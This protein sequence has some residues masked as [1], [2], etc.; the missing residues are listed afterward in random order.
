MTANRVGASEKTPFLSQT[1]LVLSNVCAGNA[2]AQ[3][4]RAFHFAE[5]WAISHTCCHEQA[6]PDSASG[7]VLSNRTLQRFFLWRR[8]LLHRLE[9]SVSKIFISAARI[10][11]DDLHFVS[12]PEILAVEVASLKGQT[13]RSNR[14]A[15]VFSSFS[16]HQFGFDRV[17][18]D[19]F[20]GAD[21]SS[22]LDDWINGNFAWRARG[23]WFCDFGTHQ[24]LSPAV[25]G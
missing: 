11:F 10:D 4:P 17:D 16:A 23:Q 15:C 13:V 20:S 3:Q 18:A 5:T 8:K 6:I 2:G 14:R 7:L 22:S 19:C 12:R 1:K 25:I 9:L 21:L 24:L